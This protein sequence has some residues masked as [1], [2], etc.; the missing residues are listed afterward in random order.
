MFID[1]SILYLAHE[2]GCPYGW[3][4]YQGWCYYSN[5]EHNKNEQLTFHV[6]RENC[7]TMKANIVSVH[8]KEENDFLGSIIPS[9]CLIAV[10]VM[11]YTMIYIFFYKLI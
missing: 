7:L 10:P 8:S 1:V 4:H 11:K 5:A 9:K 2:T 3:H 6:A